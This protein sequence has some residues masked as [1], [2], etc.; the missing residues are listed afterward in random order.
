MES[1]RRV[2]WAIAT[3]ALLG[4]VFAGCGADDPPQTDPPTG[5]PSSSQ[6]TA[7]A[8]SAVGTVRAWVAARNDALSTGDTA[9]AA[10]LAASCDT[11]EDVLAGI[12]RERLGA[13]WHV[14]RALVTEQSGD[15][16]TVLADI[17]VTRP[18]DEMSLRFVVDP[19]DR[20]PVRRLVFLL[21]RAAGAAAGSAGAMIGG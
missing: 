21:P 11:C 5:Q 19:S 14:D 10:A 1:S 18:R 12:K 17:T 6:V 9:A 8:R 2:G 3:A 20:A 15:T 13:R 4:F 16:A 7:P